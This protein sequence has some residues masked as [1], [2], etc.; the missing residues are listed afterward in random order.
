MNA[1]HVSPLC[2]SF[3]LLFARL[4]PK[5]RNCLSSTS[6]GEFDIKS[7]ARL[8]F[9][10]AIT[11]RILCSPQIDKLVYELYELTPD[12]IKIVEGAAT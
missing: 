4:I 9:G 12:E 11:S 1:L 8:F 3:F 10:K 7:I 6:A 2:Y 5:S